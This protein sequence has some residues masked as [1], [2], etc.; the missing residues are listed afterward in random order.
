MRK[1]EEKY[2]SIRQGLVQVDNFSLLFV[3]GR[4]HWNELS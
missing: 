3:G 2:F 4:R 1:N